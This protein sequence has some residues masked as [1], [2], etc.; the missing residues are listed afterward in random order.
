MIYPNIKQIGFAW[1]KH[2]PICWQPLCDIVYSSGPPMA[3]RAMSQRQNVR[4]V[5]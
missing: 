2:E 1:I 5:A 3:N 4:K